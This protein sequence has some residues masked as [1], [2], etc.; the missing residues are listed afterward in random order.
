[1]VDVKNGSL[2]VSQSFF[3]KDIYIYLLKYY[4]EGKVERDRGKNKICDFFMIF[5]AK[6]EKENLNPLILTF[7][8]CL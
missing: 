2:L 7:L 3:Q 6:F 4:F 8:C 5:G 1:M